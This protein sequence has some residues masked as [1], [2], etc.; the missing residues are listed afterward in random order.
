MTDEQYVTYVRSKMWEKS[1]RHIVE[2]RRRREE[3]RRK[4]KEEERRAK[5]EGRR[6]RDGLEEALKR[7]EERRRCGRWVGVWERYNKGWEELRLDAEVGA[8]GKDLK[9]RIAWPVASGSRTDMGKDGVESFYRHAPKAAGSVLDLGD[10]LKKERVRWH[11]DKMQQ[12]A[13]SGGLD[14]ETMKIVTAVFQVV[15]RLWSETKG[16]I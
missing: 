10:V 16:T 9:D 8:E 6:W 12:R 4:R 1:H 5:E 7:G 15:D 2:E 11:P 14:A 13:G 3:E